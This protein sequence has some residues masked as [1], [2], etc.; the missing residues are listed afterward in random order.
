M[1]VLPRYVDELDFEHAGEPLHVLEQEMYI[2]LV[3]QN[4]HLGNSIRVG[5]EFGE[6]EIS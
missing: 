4:N 3:F 2:R 1:L 5:L 6:K